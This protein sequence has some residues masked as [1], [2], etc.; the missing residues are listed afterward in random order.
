MKYVTVKAIGRIKT[1]IVK[2]GESIEEQMRRAMKSG[3]PINATAKVEYSNRGDGV[4]PQ[5]DIRTDR[6]EY[7]RMATDRVH[8]TSYAARMEADGY[9]RGEDGGWSK[10]TATQEGAALES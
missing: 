2:D 6:F 1:D 5:F 10:P 9:V 4:P 8:A 3:E 7:A